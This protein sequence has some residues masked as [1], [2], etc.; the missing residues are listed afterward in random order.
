MNWLTVETAGKASPEAK[1]QSKPAIYRS[2]TKEKSDDLQRFSC[3]QQTRLNVI[4]WRADNTSWCV[5]GS[6]ALSCPQYQSIISCRIISLRHGA[7]MS[8]DKSPAEDVSKSHSS[9]SEETIRRTSKRPS[10]RSEL[11]QVGARHV[12]VT[13]TRSGLLHARREESVFL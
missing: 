11:G 12:Q 6:G 5:A 10:L 4:R 9:S 2:K 3:W 1:P 7:F 8:P 13:L